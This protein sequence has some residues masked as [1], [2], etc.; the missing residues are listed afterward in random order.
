MRLIHDV[1]A[2]FAKSQETSL[3]T[4]LLVPEAGLKE[5]RSTSESGHPTRVPTMMDIG[6]YTY[7]PMSWSYP[8]L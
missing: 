1:K 7:I 5:H 2:N 8:I 3:F 6:I 4:L